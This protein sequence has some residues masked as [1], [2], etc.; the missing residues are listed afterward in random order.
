MKS[1]G[2]VACIVSL[3]LAAVPA[4]LGNPPAIAAERYNREEQVRID[5]YQKASPAVVTL[6]TARSSGSGSI[7]DATGLILTNEH[8]I[9]G[10]SN[11]QVVAI[12]ADGRRYPGRVIAVDRPNDLALVQ[13]QTRERF[14]T[15]ALADPNSIRVGQEVYAIGSPFGLSGTFTTGILS[16]IDENGDLQTDAALNQGNSGGPL[17]NSR[18]ELIGVNKAILSPGGRG[19]IGIGFATSAT[20]ARPLLAR[21]REA[22]ASGATTVEPPESAR[23]RLGV[24]VAADLV[25]QSIERNSLAARLGL[26][27]GDRIVAINRHRLRSVN[28]LIA[29]ME[30]QPDSL[31]LTIARDRRFATLE[32]RF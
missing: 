12:A 31:L 18:G 27:P 5:V 22:I 32:V 26:R 11:G 24:E 21:A 3:S 19:N 14:P 15:I 8:V 1:E 9:R 30:R 29:F 25:I 13:L 2:L 28:E 23:P 20:A 17:L 7:I 16:R 10:A 6:E 4:I